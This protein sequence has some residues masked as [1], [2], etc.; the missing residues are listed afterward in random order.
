MFLSAFDVS[1][2]VFRLF[3]SLVVDDLSPA[4]LSLSLIF[5]TYLSSLYLSLFLSLILKVKSVDIS[6]ESYNCSLRARKFKKPP[7]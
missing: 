5:C 3:I 7:G 2:T 1:D 6:E 4:S